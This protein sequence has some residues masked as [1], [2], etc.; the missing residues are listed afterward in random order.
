MLELR[1][2]DLEFAFFGAGTLSENIENQRGP[3]ENLAIEHIFQIATLSGRKLV[4]KDDRV[5]ILF[6]AM[7]GKF[8]RFSCADKSACHWRFELLRAVTDHFCA[9]GIGQ[10]VKFGERILKFPGGA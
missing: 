10:F 4:I 9:G 3:V 7:G 6:A 1:Q 5:D 2:F 8:P